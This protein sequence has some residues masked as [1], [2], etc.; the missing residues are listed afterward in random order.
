M[1]FR[2]KYAVDAT[3]RGKTHLLNKKK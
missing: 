3:P 1:F 2:R